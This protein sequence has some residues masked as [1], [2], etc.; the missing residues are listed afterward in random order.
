MYGIEQK[1]VNWLKKQKT[2]PVS[3]DS[4]P[5]KAKTT[6]NEF[7]SVENKEQSVNEVSTKENKN[8]TST[9]KSEMIENVK[10]YSDK[11]KGMVDDEYLKKMEY[12]EKS[13]DEIND[14]ANK[15]AQ[16]NYDLGKNKLDAEIDKKRQESLQN[17]EK[18]KA[19]DGV[20][21]QSID[22][23][24]ENLFDNAQNKAVKNGIARSSIYAETIKNLSEDKIQEYL[25]VDSE[26]ASSLKDNANKLQ[27]YENEYNS[28]IS[29]LEI[30]KAIDV[31]EKI[32][33]LNKEQQKRIDEVLK[34][35]NSIDEKIYKLQSEG[36]QLPSDKES[37]E[38]K[39]QMLS[40]ALEYYY[41][42]DPKVALDEFKNDVDVQ[43]LLGGL[44]SVVESYLKSR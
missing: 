35:N 39:R 33:E 26:V 8:Q 14:L 40:S 34:Y 21:K 36:K 2:Q 3:S 10:K 24:Y 30:E 18:I 4:E 17:E 20:K 37:A 23:K 41:S 25:N 5:K 32:E 29:A 31:K 43:Y 22:Q 9:V 12:T 38:Y 1:I 19:Q 28:A 7:N 42:L 6:S 15:Y 11:L 27:A 16:D 44:S 13:Q